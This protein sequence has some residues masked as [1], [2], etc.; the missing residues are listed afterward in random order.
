MEQTGQPLSYDELAVLVMV[1]KSR[2]EEV[3]ARADR[4]EAENAELRRRAGL[5]SRN[6]AKPPSADGL[7]EMDGHV[8]TVASVS[9]YDQFTRC[10]P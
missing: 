4:L 10:C 7:P 1:L 9:R 2:L 8:S 3:E 5:N 6:S